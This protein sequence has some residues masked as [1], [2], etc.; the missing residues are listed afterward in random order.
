MP[1]V[2]S[3]ILCHSLTSS[4]KAA[5]SAACVLLASLFRLSVAL[6]DTRNPSASSLNA[7]TCTLIC[8]RNHRLYM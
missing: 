4:C 7:D 6:S 8:E 1:N 2:T 3:Q 5:I